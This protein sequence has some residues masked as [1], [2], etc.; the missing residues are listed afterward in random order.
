MPR[1]AVAFWSRF[2]QTGCRRSKRPWPAPRIRPHLSGR[3]VMDASA[4]ALEQSAAVRRREV[5]AGE[6]VDRYLQRI[7]RLNPLLNAFWLTTPELARRQAEEPGQGLLSGAPTSVKDLS[8]M[9]GYPLTFG[10]RAFEDNVAQVDSF[11]V[12]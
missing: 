1:P 12:S 8:A 5:T 11:V 6:L 10:S 3:W 7:E 9:A 2:R 4:S